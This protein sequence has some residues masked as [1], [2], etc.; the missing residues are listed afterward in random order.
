MILLAAALAGAGG[1]RDLGLVRMRLPE[2]ARQVPRAWL[3]VFGPYRA[4]LFWGLDIGSGYST[5]IRYSGLYVLGACL[6]FLGSPVLGAGVLGLYG[7]AH[8]AFMTADI[9]AECVSPAGR[10]G[11]LGLSR[12]QPLYRVSGL[13]HL[14]VAAWLFTCGV[15]V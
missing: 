10:H 15:V 12:T 3:A 1:L 7:L 14:G 11:L 4:G 9:L 6:L 2:P 13:A 5:M 8:G